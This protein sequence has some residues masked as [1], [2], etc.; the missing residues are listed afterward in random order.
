MRLEF[1]GAD[2]SMGL[3]TR[4]VYEVSII[5]RWPSILVGVCMKPRTATFIRY[6]SIEAF[7]QNWRTVL[8]FEKR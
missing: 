3:R 8:S 2:R 5:S 6:S 4:K 1:I 7:M